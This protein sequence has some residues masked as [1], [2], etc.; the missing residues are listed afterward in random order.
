MRVL[1][2]E[3]NAG[4]ARR[5]CE[6]L[7]GMGVRA[8]DVAVAENL[9]AFYA[10]TRYD[11]PPIVVLDMTFDVN[12]EK[13]GKE[14]AAGIEV[15]QALAAKSDTVRVVI[16]TQHGEFTYRGRVFLSADDLVAFLSRLYPKM[17]VGLVK[18]DLA[19]D[20]WEQQL[21]N[22]YAQCISVS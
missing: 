13:S 11:V 1:V 22:L 16:A 15:L 20:A 7:E 8:S 10:Q 19:T 4:K 6:L 9:T 18:V 21:R 5:I 14:E 2:V 3:D 12:G 17:V